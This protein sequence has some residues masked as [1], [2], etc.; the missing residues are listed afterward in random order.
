[1]TPTLAIALTF[2]TNQTPKGPVEY[3]LLAPDGPGPHPAILALPPG[4]QTRDMVREGLAPWQ[5]QMV[6]DGFMVLSPVAPDEGLYTCATAHDRLPALLDH[7]AATHPVEGDTWHLFGISNGGRSALVVGPAYADRFRS[8]TVLPGATA[9][10][11]ALAG[12]EMPITFMVGSQDGGWLES[13]RQAHGL[14]ESRGRNTELVVLEGQGH[15]AFRAVDWKT[16]RARI[17]R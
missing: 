6:A 10:P 12:L 11:E 1:M 9:E 5:D 16:L 13:S 4:P 14:L 8:V 15:T 17:T 2:H 3:A 7:V